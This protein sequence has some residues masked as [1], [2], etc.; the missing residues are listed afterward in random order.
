MDHVWRFFRNIFVKLIRNRNLRFDILSSFFILQVLTASSIIYYTYS[1]NSDTMVDFSLKMIDDTSRSKIDRITNRFGS[2]QSDIQMGSYIIRDIS[3]ITINNK[4]LLDYCIAVVKNNPFLESVFIATETGMFF[5][6]KR[7]S[8]GSTYRSSPNK[9]LP[10]RAAYA[11]RVLERSE[12]S[13][14]EVWNYLDQDSNILESEQLPQF[15]VTYDPRVRDWYQRAMQTRSNSWSDIYIFSTT[16]QPGIANSYPLQSNQGKEFG[17]IGADIPLEGFKEILGDIHFNGLSMILTGKGEVVASPYNEET[18]RVLGNETQLVNVADL[19]EKI[20]GAAFKQYLS[21]GEKKTVFPYNGKEYVA[22]FKSFEGLLF[23]NWLFMI[24]MPEDE[25]VG[26]IKTTQ[27][28]TMLISLFILIVSI[29]LISYMAH[30]IARPIV[31]LA[32]QANSI[33]QFDLSD[34]REVHSG[35]LEIQLLQS[36]IT[37]MRRSLV[38]FG[39]FVPRSLVRKLIDKGGEVKI[40]GRNKRVTIFFSD[41]AGFTTVSETYPPDKLMVHL[42][43]YLEA[44]TSIIIKEQGTIDKYIGDAIMAFWG[45]PQSDRDHALHACKA[46]LHCQKRL[47]DLNRKWN[48]E[49]KP[50]LETRI[51]I[52]TGDVIVGN[53][54]SSER[55]NYTILG[56]NVNLAARLEGVNKVFHTHIII[57]EETL[58]LVRDVAI[59]RPLDVVAVKG[60][61]IGIKIYELIALT[62]SDP[63]LVPT[64]EQI[65]FSRQFDKA[66]NLYH[67]QRWEEAIAGFE[68]INQL[69][70]KDVTADMYIKRCK[71][72]QEHPPGPDWDGVF[73]LETK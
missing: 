56:D 18:A 45:A 64:D 24:V 22:I 3:D 5:Q 2:V 72:F 52:H 69:F 66:F 32:R 67:E 12:G 53:M 33:T 28:Q 8:P 1:H 13:G 40:G 16:K 50:I 37:A 39:K 14:T 34:P 15:Q 73:H 10:K 49:K 4:I 54:G 48:F 51:G 55:L 70:G 44:L 17:V 26:A 57:S 68:R 43:E 63:M 19:S 61:N 65:D 35:I 58:H 31:W 20:P 11:V 42:S 71:V 23:K 30:R 25:L 46:A 29:F 59:V 60:K 36:S 47:A 9:L 21:T 27:H 7:L 38:S 41:I 6:V 62:A